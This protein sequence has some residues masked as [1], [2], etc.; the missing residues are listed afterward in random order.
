MMQRRIPLNVCSIQMGTWSAIL[1]EKAQIE[2]GHFEVK[3]LAQTD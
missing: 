3:V 2:L 1:C